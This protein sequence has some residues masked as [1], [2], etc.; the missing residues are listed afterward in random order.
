MNGFNAVYSN[1]GPVRQVEII[2]LTLGDI[3][4]KHTTHRNAAPWDATAPWGDA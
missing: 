2:V 4:M 1:C 3:D